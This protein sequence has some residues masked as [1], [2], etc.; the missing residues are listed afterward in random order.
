[1]NDC[2]FIW[3]GGCD[4]CEMGKCD[5]YLSANS[6]EGSRLLEEYQAEVEEVLKPIKE[7]FKTRI[8]NAS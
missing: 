3:F 1:M 5:K 7:K 4:G 8:E 2:I 6:E